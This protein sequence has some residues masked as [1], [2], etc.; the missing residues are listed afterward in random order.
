MISR[1]PRPFDGELIWS[2]VARYGRRIG[3]KK[4]SF[5]PSLLLGNQHRWLNAL[6]PAHLGSLSKVL[7]SEFQLDP[8]AIRDRHTLYRI[9]AAGLPVALANRLS[10]LMIGNLGHRWVN[11]AF[12][13]NLGL[14]RQYR[15]KYCPKCRELDLQRFGEAGWRTSHQ[16]PGVACCHEHECALIETPVLALAKESIPLDQID[17]G[18]NPM[19]QDFRAEE[20]AE[21]AHLLLSYREALPPI[22]SILVAL[23]QQNIVPGD[24]FRLLQTTEKERIAGLITLFLPSVA[25]LIAPTRGEELAGITVALRARRRAVSPLTLLSATVATGSTIPKVISLAENLRHDERPPFPCVNPTCERAGQNVIWKMR[26]HRFHNPPRAV[27]SCPACGHSY[28]RPLPLRR[29]GPGN[30]DF[31]WTTVPQRNFSGRTETERRARLESRRRQ[32]LLLAARH[33]SELD[34]Q[35]NERFRTLR[36]LLLDTD[37]EWLGRHTRIYHRGECGRTDIK[38]QRVNW[39]DRERQMLRHLE[40]IL[41]SPSPLGSGSRPRPTVAQLIRRLSEFGPLTFYGLR[42]MPALHRRIRREAK[43]LFAFATLK[44]R[45][46]PASKEA[47]VPSSEAVRELLGIPAKTA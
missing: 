18:G 30:T 29:T 43:S 12:R 35:L 4:R 40:E 37:R 45:R 27:F 28:R 19:P 3:R 47:G 9:A 5:L 32:Y 10:E 14:H 31:A 7:P 33:P 25:A 34:V 39:K 1:F 38:R 2:T 44:S 17:P 26:L 20:Y 15:L 16:I 36:Q 6:L 46:A 41:D 42:K 13:R 11:F 21:Q 22:D 23:V 8:P 24:P